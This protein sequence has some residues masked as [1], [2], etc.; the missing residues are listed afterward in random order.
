MCITPQITTSG[1]AMTRFDFKGQAV[2]NSL[3]DLDLSAVN[4][5]TYLTNKE[6][7]NFKND[8]SCLI[9]LHLNVRG[10]INKQ[11][12]LN[13]I[14][15]HKGEN[16]V[17]YALLCETWLRKETHNLINIPGF[18]YH[19]TYRE[20]RRGGG[21]GI[22]IRENVKSKGREDLEINSD[23]LENIIVEIKGD[24]TSILLASCYRAPNT[25]QSKFLSDYNQ[26]ISQLKSQNCLFVIGIDHNLDL[27]K[28]QC[29]SKYSDFS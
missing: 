12:E 9:T 5:C 11:S 19:R 7:L 21:V 2:S 15:T 14:L 24:K 4:S 1:N 16:K 23:S 22:L 20:G 29:T 3:T 26:L 25:D 13:K 10:L 27:L 28:K 6:Y 8:K 17:D 18:T